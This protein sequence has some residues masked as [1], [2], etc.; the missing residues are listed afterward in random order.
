MQKMDIATLPT[1]IRPAPTGWMTRVRSAFLGER[2]PADHAPVH[3]VAAANAI[4]EHC[5]SDGQKP[6]APRLQ[7]LIMLTDKACMSRLGRRF[8]DRD[9]S[10]ALDMPYHPDVSRTFRRWNTEP[11]GGFGDH[12]VIAFPHFEAIDAERL[13]VMREVVALCKPF[14]TF[15]IPREA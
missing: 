4:L 1:A 6:N 9:P 10:I 15:K 13:A 5:W 8:T 11:I 7:R 12:D 3:P 14:A 2:A